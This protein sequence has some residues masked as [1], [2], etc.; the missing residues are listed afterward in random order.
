MLERGLASVAQ[1]HGWSVAKREDFWAHMIQRLGI[2]LRRPYD[3]V[4]DGSQ[5]VERPRW[6]VGA[7][8][9]IVESCF[10]ADADK[11][12]AVYHDESGARR[13]CS[14]G[15]LAALASRVAGGLTR[16]GL[17]PGDA[18]AIDLPMHVEA[19]AAYLGIIA[20]GMVVVSIADSL[21]PQEI[22]VRL[23]LSGTKAVITQDEI[24]RGG[25]RQAI[26]ALCQGGRSRRAAD[27]RDR[28]FKGHK[29]APGRP[30]VGR[31]A[32]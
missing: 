17:A 11:P 6:L 27:G 1:L 2:R 25:R 3:E 23:R 26:A 31:S 21:A 13:T 7:K 28:E 12:A 29:A 4:L 24:L 19:V 18:V 32:C 9:N 8:L 10:A 5:G 14:Y 16:A 15:E 30:G 20:A 22:A